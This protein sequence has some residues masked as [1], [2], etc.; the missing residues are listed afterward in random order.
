MRS[1]IKQTET[2]RDIVFF[3]RFDGQGRLFSGG[4]FKAKV[5]KEVCFKGLLTKLYTMNKQQR[6]KPCCKTKKFIIFRENW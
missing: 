3:V 6:Q 1:A 2:K 4:Q 5:M